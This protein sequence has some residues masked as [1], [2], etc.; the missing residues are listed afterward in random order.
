[1][2]VAESNGLRHI[3]APLT[4]DEAPN[5][6][7]ARRND[8]NDEKRMMNP[9]LKNPNAIPLARFRRSGI[10]LSFDIRHSSFLEDIFRLCDILL[11]PN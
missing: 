4:N 6:D 8:G 11:K 3:T 9:T 5:N 10:N 7:E 2:S 1:L